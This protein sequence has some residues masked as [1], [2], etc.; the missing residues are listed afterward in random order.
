MKKEYWD[1][2]DEQVIEKTGKTIDEWIQIL[3]AFDAK[4]KKSND[5]VAHLQNEYQV[6][7]YWA[8]TLTTL[9]TKSDG[10]AL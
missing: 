4:N 5:V 7:R 3:T 2:S 10:R 6:P 9:F 1:V 8:R